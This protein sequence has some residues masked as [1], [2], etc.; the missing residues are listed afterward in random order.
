M[1][2]TSTLCSF[3]VIAF[4]KF[5][6][7]KSTRA[8]F[9]AFLKFFGTLALQIS[10][11]DRPKTNVVN[12]YQMGIFLMSTVSNLPCIYGDITILISSVC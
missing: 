11:A 12:Y 9:W 5:A 7:K 2:Q 1:P 6:K 10:K 4:V 3:M 8:V